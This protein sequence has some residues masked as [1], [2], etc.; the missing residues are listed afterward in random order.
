ML[1]DERIKEAELNVRL[2][3][4]DGLLKKEV[5]DKNIY[6]IFYKNAHDSLDIAQFLLENN[7]SDLWIIV[8]S[9]YAMFYI[10]N[11]V[12]YKLGYK[13][14]EKIA[15]KVTA[16]AL[17]VFVRNKLRK[18]LLEEYQKAQEEALAGI[19]AD[20]LIKTFDLE[21]EKRSEVQYQMK[22]FELHG[23]AKTSL[24]RAKEFL[25]E[26]EKLL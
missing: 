4:S 9:Y 1:D 13:V 21:R 2:Y 14:G 19:K 3:I 26:M 20:S 22:E 12:L 16:D 11:A 25:L 6:F 7:K 18:S 17:V 5:F 10:A 23:R 24:N 8:T 15:H